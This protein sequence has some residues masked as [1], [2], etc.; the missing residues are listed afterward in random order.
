MSFLANVPL[1][2]VTVLYFL[3]RLFESL[4]I[5]DYSTGFLTDS[6]L[7]SR[8]II[9]ILICVIAVSSSVVIMMQKQSSRKSPKLKMGVLGL[10]AGVLFIV[11]AVLSIMHTFRV[12]GF[13]GFD[14]LI[15]LS[16]IGYIISLL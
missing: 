16:G 11:G 2:A 7:V 1:L 10:I 5:T 13:L 14:I 15:L 3:G 9:V 12:G 4:K 6:P 8:A